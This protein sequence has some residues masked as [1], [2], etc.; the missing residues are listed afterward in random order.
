[1]ASQ[2]G[3]RLAFQ[4]ASNAVKRA[5]QSP[6]NAVLSQSFLRLETG[7]VAG[8][9]QYKFDVLVNEN[10]QTTNFNTQLKLNLQD[11]F[12]VS[13]IGIFVASPASATDASYRLLTYPNKTVFGANATALN[14]IYNGYMQLTINQRTIVPNW[15]LYKHLD[16]PTTQQ[17]TVTGGYAAAAISP[18]VLADDQNNGDDFGFYPCEPNLVLVGSKKNELTITLPAGLATVNANSRLVVVFRGILAQ[19]TTSVN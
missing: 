8:N 1:M 19:N 18:A 11:S 14:T 6:A 12:I 16:V 13:Q 15:D 3:Q 9:T 4:N 7:L 17:N 5:G 2:L 10:T